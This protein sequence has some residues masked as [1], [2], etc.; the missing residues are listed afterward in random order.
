MT[1]KTDV[2]PPLSVAGKVTTLMD[3][4]HSSAFV[5]AHEEVE[6]KR[7]IDEEFVKL[8]GKPLNF[9]TGGYLVLC[10]IY[11]RPEEIKTIKNVEGKDVTL[12]RPKI[13]LDEDKFQ[14]C[15]ALVCGIGP[16]A[17]KDKE[18]NVWPEGPTARIGDWIVLPRFESNV[19]YYKGVAMALIPDDRIMGVINDPEDIQSSFVGGK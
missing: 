7:I 12:W 3:A 18:G 11:I 16:R 1:I 19:I 5:E 8:T 14:S 13:S 9:R 10:R 17:F 15:V 6:A 2:P 4:P